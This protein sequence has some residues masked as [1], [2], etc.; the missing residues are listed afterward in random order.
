MKAILQERY[1]ST[2]VL[3]LAEVERP[4]PEDDEVLIRVRASSVHADVW[5]VMTGLPYVLRIMGSG[6]WRPKNPIPGTDLAGIV[7]AVGSKVTRFTPGDEVFGET[8]RGMQW[9]NGGLSPRSDS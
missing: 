6:L 7:E 1:G 8:L 9:M 3:H 2:E 5:H 4:T